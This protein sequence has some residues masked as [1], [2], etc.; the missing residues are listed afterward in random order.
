MKSLPRIAGVVLVLLLLVVGYGIFR[1]TSPVTPPPGSALTPALQGQP[2]VN[3]APLFTAQRL[4]QMPT[5]AEEQPFAQ[6]ALRDGV[7]VA[8]APALSPSNRHTD[9]LRLSFSGPPE[10][11]DE[12]VRRLAETWRHWR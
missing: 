7:A 10:L 1:T 4:A 11:L 3:Q 8:T 9:R 6:E 12:G 5:L 2:L